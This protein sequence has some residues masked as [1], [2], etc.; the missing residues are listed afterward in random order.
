MRWSLFWDTL[1]HPTLPQ[2]DTITWKQQQQLPSQQR[3]LSFYKMPH[4]YTQWTLFRHY[5]R[6][7]ELATCCRVL[8][9]PAEASFS[10][11]KFSCSTRGGEVFF[12]IVGFLMIFKKLHLLKCTSKSELKNARS[13]ILNCESF[14]AAATMYLCCI[15]QAVRSVKLLR[16]WRTLEKASTY[17][18]PSTVPQVLSSLSFP[19]EIEYLNCT[20]KLKLAITKFIFDSISR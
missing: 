6:G 7:F 4:T 20:T 17:A 8:M 11:L 16:L 3:R 14:P 1:W 18:L 10:V 2:L 12:K 9:A 19:L 15:G 13:W 5:L